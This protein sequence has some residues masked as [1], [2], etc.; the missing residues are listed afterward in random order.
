MPAITKLREP[1]Q[2]IY[3]S[4]CFRPGLATNESTKILHDT[5]NGV[6]RSMLRQWAA[7]KWV[8][9][10]DQIAS[11]CERE[12]AKIED[13]LRDLSTEYTVSK[14]NPERLDS[15]MSSL[16]FVHT[17]QQ[18][19]DERKVFV[20]WHAVIPLSELAH[21]DTALLKELFGGSVEMDTECYSFNAGRVLAGPKFLS[22]NHK[23]V[24]GKYDG[25]IR[26]QVRH[27]L[28]QELTDR[29]L[30]KKPLYKKGPLR[31]IIDSLVISTLSR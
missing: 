2:S 13:Q 7:Q 1:Y 30:I 10:R 23:Q 24:P 22:E 29:D 28:N 16:D 12:L 9:S 15:V 5:F 6:L 8:P 26:R 18:L 3:D 11:A 21:S 17:N 25:V 19:V 31:K 27:V 4:F 20:L 14:P